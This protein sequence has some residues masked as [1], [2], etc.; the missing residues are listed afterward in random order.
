MIR[1]QEM[2]SQTDT[3]RVFVSFYS[4]C[5]QDKVQCVYSPFGSQLACII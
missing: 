5:V 1:N 4:V 3:P 2:F